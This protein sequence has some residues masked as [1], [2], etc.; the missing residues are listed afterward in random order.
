MTATTHSEIT[1]M[2]VEGLYA[3]AM[4]LADSARSYFDIEGAADRAA[5]TP[6][7]RVAFSCESL[8]VTTRLMH[9]VAWLMVRKA[10]EAGEMTA[11]A[12]LAPERRLGR[13]PE[14][15][16]ERQTAAMLPRRARAIVASSRDLYDRVR[17]LDGQLGQMGDGS[18]SEQ[19]ARALLDR[20][21]A[22]M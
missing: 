8:K 14:G 2:L 16:N 11:E 4:I 9:V 1:P 15:D 17:R 21:R 7:A 20:L 13:A 12:A 18:G 10:V 6:M 22:S 19:G 3:E 5:L